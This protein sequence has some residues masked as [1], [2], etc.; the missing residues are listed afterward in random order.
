MADDANGELK[1]MLEHLGSPPIDPTANVLKL[2]EEAVRRLDDIA[3]IRAAHI[4][5]MMVLRATHQQELSAAEKERLNAIRS[6]DA[7]AIS[8]AS[9]QVNSVAQ[10][11]ET[12]INNL[13]EGNRQQ[14]ASMA[15][16]LQDRL[17]SVERNQYTG[18]GAK[19][20]QVEGQQQ[21]N[22]TVI[23]AIGGVGLFFTF[24]TI[25]ISIIVVVIT[26]ASG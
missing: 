12:K 16:L 25:V 9:Q 23:A 4:R 6:I 3:Q 21:T 17:S 26:L 5:E 18:Q 2:V 1:E 8:L 20:Q 19:S 11:L 14:L 13:A 10:G 15:T 7:Q 22:W 24:V